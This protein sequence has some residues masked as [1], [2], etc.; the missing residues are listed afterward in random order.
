ML[1]L[2]GHGAI[3][4]CEQ[5]RTSAR[6]TEIEPWLRSL[7]ARQ[8]VLDIIGDLLA[9]RRQLKHLV[10]DDRIVGLL[11]KLPI[12]GRL[13]P[14]IVRPIHAAQSHE[15]GRDSE[16]KAKKRSARVTDLSG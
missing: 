8:M 1:A 4:K 15:L 7:P 9:D 11:G 13:V 16:R 6:A 10:L 14:E 5:K 3:P 12:H 2:Y